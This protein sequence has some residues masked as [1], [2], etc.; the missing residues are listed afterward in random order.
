MMKRICLALLL[1][2]ACLSSG[3][4]VEK[5]NLVIKE[6]GSATLRVHYGMTRPVVKQL[7]NAETVHASL[8]S[9][10][11]SM[12]PFVNPYRFDQAYI[13]KALAPYTEKGITVTGIRLEQKSG[14]EYAT[15]DLDLNTVSS[16]EALA[17]CELFANHRYSLAKRDDGDYLL[18]HRFTRDQAAGTLDLE[19]PDTMENVRPLLSGLR[20]T[21]EIT[22]PEYIKESNAHTKGVRTG[23]WDYDFDRNAASINRIQ[24]DKRQLLFQPDKTALPEFDMAREDEGDHSPPSR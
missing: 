1:A 21:I 16:L 3:C 20:V 17:S 24:K 22:L 10:D 6:D 12:E 13:E 5:H 4:L 2:A 7:V 23:E 11:E 18:T 9:S 19:D 8:A 15:I 14:W